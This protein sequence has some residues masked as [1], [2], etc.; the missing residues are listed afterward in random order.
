M[1]DVQTGDGFARLTPSSRMECRICWYVYDP[2]SGDAD[3]QILPGT[4]FQML[5]DYWRCPQCDAAPDKFL[6][7]DD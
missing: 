7:I 5:P 4:P 6:P 3:T 2:A 1:T